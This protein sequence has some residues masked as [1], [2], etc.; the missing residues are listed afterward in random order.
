M[1]GAACLYSLLREEMMALLAWVCSQTIN[2]S[3][4]LSQRRGNAFLPVR[5]VVFVSHQDLCSVGG[6]AAEI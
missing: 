3:G 2:T 4:V 6:S 1:R 5:N